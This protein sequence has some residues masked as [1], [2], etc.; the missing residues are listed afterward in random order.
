MPVCRSIGPVRVEARL[1]RF[2][3]SGV[4]FESTF[5]AAGPKRP[6]S[7]NRALIAAGTPNSRISVSRNSLEFP[8]AR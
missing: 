3:F 1:T 5:H 6:E 2:F 8:I 4:A 7:E